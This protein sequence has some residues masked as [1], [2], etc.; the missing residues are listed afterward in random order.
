[1]INNY[2]I[3]SPLRIITTQLGIP[4]DYKQQCIEE[5]YKL[6]DSQNKKTNVQAIMSTY[7]V[8]KETN[9]F[10]NL[11]SN[12]G[13]IIKESIIDVFPTSYSFN[14]KNVWSAIYKK[15][16]YTKP[17]AHFP[18]FISFVYYLQ[19]SGNTP[20]I[21]EG[22]DFKINPKDDMLVLFPSYIEHSVPKH[23]EEKDRICL[24]GNIEM[25]I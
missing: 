12:I 16:H 18:F 3:K 20:I 10:N 14:F 4:L 17:H 1:M 9:V 8:F 23:K 21:F 13:S 15:G 24:A 22:C 11:I 2:Y 25:I 5:A 6:G 19:S 7:E